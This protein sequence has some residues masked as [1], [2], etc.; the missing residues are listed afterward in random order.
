MAPV[1]GIDAV[2]GAKPIGQ[3]T[4][5]H[6]DL[7][8]GQPLDREIRDAHSAIPS[9]EKLMSISPVASLIAGFGLLVRQQ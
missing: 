4:V 3:R 1:V 7:D 9:I 6:V 2:H 8:I 5:R